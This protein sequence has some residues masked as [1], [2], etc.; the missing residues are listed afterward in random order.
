MLSDTHKLIA[1]S[2]FKTLQAE[3]KINIDYGSFRHGCIAPDIYP[4]MMFMS[5][6]FDGSIDLVNENIKYLCEHML[7]GDKKSIKKFSFRLGVVIHFISDYFCKA[8]ND[9]RY[10]NLILHYIYERN[11]ERFLKRR[12]K[13]LEL[14]P[15]VNAAVSNMKGK[16]SDFIYEKHLEYKKM[17]FSM[18]ND[19]KYT[20]SV[21]TS[22]ALKIVSGCMAE[23]NNGL[24]R[25]IA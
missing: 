14:M 4:S 11:L 17:R 22:V 23:V 24:L 5:H 20:L 16:I 7:P 18:S 3:L 8:H 1:Q 21:S 12:V 2:I 13:A 19:L 15:A 25:E 6:S 10:D 9:K